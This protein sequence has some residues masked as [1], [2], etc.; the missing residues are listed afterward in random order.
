MFAAT[1]KQGAGWSD[2]LAVRVVGRGVRCNVREAGKLK[3]RKIN[4]TV[5]VFPNASHFPSPFTAYRHFT[6]CCD[7]PTR[8]CLRFTLLK[9]HKAAPDGIQHT[10]MAY[11]ILRERQVLTSNIQFACSR[12]WFDQQRTKHSTKAPSTVQLFPNSP[13]FWGPLSDSSF[14]NEYTP[15]HSTA[16]TCH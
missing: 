1:C 13:A 12:C 6:E 11:K 3:K 9:H 8:P 7:T 14:R 15:L 16:S 4:V 5:R 10:M 2:C